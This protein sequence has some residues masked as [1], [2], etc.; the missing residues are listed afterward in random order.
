M[1]DS[2]GLSVPVSGGGYPLHSSHGRV[3]CESCLVVGMVGN[4]EEN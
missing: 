4:L 2:S 3:A 1:T